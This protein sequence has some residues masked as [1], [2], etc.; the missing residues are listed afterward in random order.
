MLHFYPQNFSDRSTVS[1]NS[2]SV[3]YS[4][5]STMYEVSDL[6]DVKNETVRYCAINIKKTTF[7]I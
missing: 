6:F 5:T 1:T 7:L 4:I 3:Q 2:F